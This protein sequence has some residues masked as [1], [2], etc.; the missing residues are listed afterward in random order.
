[1]DD[2]LE[3]DFAQRFLSGQTI[4]ISY[5]TYI[6]QLQTLLGTTPSVNITRAVSRLKS[7]FMTLVGKSASPGSRLQLN[8]AS[9]LRDWNNFYHP[10]GGSFIYDST[11]ELEIEFQV[12]SKLMPLYPMRSQAETFAQLKKMYGYS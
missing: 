3:N 1:M 10:M 11:K 7:I 4:P 9:L 8:A 6:V 2:Q 12:G 5:S